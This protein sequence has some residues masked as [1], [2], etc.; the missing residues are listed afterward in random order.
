MHSIHS[1]DNDKDEKQSNVLMEKMLGTRSILLTGQVNK[2]MAERFARQLLILEA[3][4]D[5]PIKVFI[6]SQGGDADSGFAILDMIRFVEPEVYTIGMGLVASAGAII[7]LGAEADHRV[8]LP[9]S[10][11]LI[12]QPLSGV[13]GV[14]TE[15]EIFAEEI[16]KM[17]TKINKLISEETGQDLEKVKED[18]DRDYWMSPDEAVEYGLISKVVTNR[19][20]L[21]A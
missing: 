2:E 18:T 7:L 9:N 16:D 6:D 4:G 10:H 20:D 5:D 11:Y 3:N 14:A 19:K 12:H 17:R 1:K 8:G 13:Q 15:I 21:G